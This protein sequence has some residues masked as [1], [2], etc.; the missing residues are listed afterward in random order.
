MPSATLNGLIGNIAARFG[1]YTS[2]TTTAG[3]TT[4]L[5]YDTFSLIHPSKTWINFYVRLM[6]NITDTTGNTS[7]ERVISDSSQDT[8]SIT[9]SPAMPSAPSS[10]VK[11][12]IKQ[13]Q[14]RDYTQAIHS[15]IYAAGDRF[16]KMVDDTTSLTM[17]VRQEYP[18]PLDL[19]VLHSVY[20]G[21]NDRWVPL[22]NYEVVGVP[23]RYMILIGSVPEWPYTAVTIP[24]GMDWQVRL[25]YTA[26]QADLANGTSALSIQ[27]TDRNT[28]FAY[29]EE[30]SLHVLNLMAVS[31]NATGEK[32]RAHLTLSENHRAEAERIKNSFN[33]KPVIRRVETRRF[34]QS[35]Y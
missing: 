12:E 24:K 34:S 14:T 31:R 4:T 18:L 21:W 3:S 25:E 9:V 23:G 11:Y 15:A 8:R 6:G 20:A 22:T 35:I 5:I 10:G 29:I 33:N 19:V 13:L 32:A 27:G 28:A 2:G 7:S 30:Y 17:N 26:M 16:M 1:N